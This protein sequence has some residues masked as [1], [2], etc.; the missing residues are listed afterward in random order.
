MKKETYEAFK[1]MLK[2]EL[3]SQGMDFEVKKVFKVNQELDGIGFGNL[4]EGVQS[5]FYLQDLFQDYQAG[6]SLTEK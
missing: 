1:E 5:V 3:K 2:Q 6:Q 4:K